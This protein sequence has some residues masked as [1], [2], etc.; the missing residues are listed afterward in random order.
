VRETFR[1]AL[2]KHGMEPRM[3]AAYESELATLPPKPAE[4]VSV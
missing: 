1:D 2:A 3:D 4:A